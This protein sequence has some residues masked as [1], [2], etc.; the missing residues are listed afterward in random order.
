ML[1]VHS[2]DGSLPRT[3]VIWLLRFMGTVKILDVARKKKSLQ[4]GNSKIRFF[5]DMSTALYK[6]RKAFALFKKQL[7]AKNISFRL[8]HPTNL[9]LDLPEGRRTFSSLMSAENY[10]KKYH[11]V[12]PK[13]RNQTAT[14]LSTAKFLLRIVS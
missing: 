10:L 13:A 3:I 2:S 11:P 8:L 5:R 1:T 6:R 9:S 12:L 14:D 7:H 4:H